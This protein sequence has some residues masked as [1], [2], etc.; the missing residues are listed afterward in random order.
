MRPHACPRRLSTPW[1]GIRRALALAMIAQ[2]LIYPLGA[3]GALNKSGQWGTPAELRFSG[4]HVAVMRKPG[5][6]SSTVFLFGESG[7]PQTMKFWRFL[8]QNDAPPAADTLL[9][10]DLPH[11]N[12]KRSDLFCSGHATLPD[13]KLLLV[14][15]AW[16]PDTVCQNVYS[17]DPA[18]TE[19]TESPWTQSATM[20]V[21]RW[22][23]TATPMAD[24]RVLASAGTMASRMSGFGGRVM[25]TGGL[26]STWRVLQTLEMAGRFAWAE[27]TAVPGNNPPDDPRVVNDYITHGEHPLGR[28]GHAFVGDPSGRGILIH[29]RYRQP[30]P[31]DSLLGDVWFMGGTIA[32]DDTTFTWRRLNPVGDASLP[33]TAMPVPRHRFAATWAGIE[34]DS[35][36]GMEQYADIEN[37]CYIHGGIDSNGK[38][39]GDLW[40]GERVPSGSVYYNWQWTRLLPDSPAT[41]RADH[42]MVYD[43]GPPDQHHAFAQLLL[44]GGRTSSDYETLAYA[45]NSTINTFGVGYSSSVI[46]LWRELT[47]DAENY[48]PPPAREGHT[49]IAKLQSRDPDEREFFLFGGESSPGTLVPADLWY[50]ERNEALADT[51]HYEWVKLT[52]ASGGPTPRRD[53]AMAYGI[54]S[55][56]LTVVGGD[57]NGSTS[58]DGYTN[59]VW[60]V[61]IGI[62]GQTMK[63][64]Q[65]PMRN[66]HPGPP[67]IAGMKMFAVGVGGAR[68]TRTLEAFS[69]SPG[70]PADS[71]CPAAAGRWQVVTDRDPESERKIADYPYMF[72]LPDGRMFNAGP[73]PGA[74]LSE[75]QYRR[76]YNM[77]IKRWTDSSGVD[78]QDAILFGSAVMYRPGKMLRAGAFSSEDDA[79]DASDRTEIAII[80]SGSNGPWVEQAPT[81]EK[82]RLEPRKNHNLTLL[83]TGDVLATGG[84]GEPDLTASVQRPRLWSVA[85]NRWNSD[86]PDDGERL[87][88]DPAKRNY[89]STAV[90]LPD[91]RVMTA[92]GEGHVGENPDQTSLSIYEPGYLFHSTGTPAIRPRVLKAPAV[93]T[94]G[95]TFT[96][97]LTDDARAA[98]ITSIALMRPGAVTHSFDQ[99]QRYV[100][101]TFSVAS[102]PTRLLVQA[103]ADA[104]VASPGDQMLFILDNR[105]TDAPNVPS[106]ARWTRTESQS[107]GVDS[108]DVVNPGTVVDLEG[109]PH[110]DQSSGELSWTEPADDGG[111]AASGAPV[112]YDIRY[113][114]ATSSPDVSDWATGW[115]TVTTSVPMVPGTPG[116]WV[117]AQVTGL[118]PNTKYWC[119][120]RT[121]DDNNQWSSHS[122]AALIWTKEGLECEGGSSGGGGGGG[123]SAGRAA[124]VHS[125]RGPATSGVF[126]NSLMDTG[127]RGI[128]NIDALRLPITPT[129]GP[130]RL[131]FRTH[132]GIGSQVDRARLLLVSHGPEEEVHVAGATVVVGAPSPIAAA[133]LLDGR[134][135]DSS[136]RLS[137]GGSLQALPGD[138]LD[139]DLGSTPGTVLVVEGRGTGGRGSGEAMGFVALTPDANGAWNELG[140]AAL[141][142][143]TDQVALSGLTGSRIRLA[144]QGGAELTGIH[145]LTLA[146]AAPQVTSVLPGGAH[147]RYS[148]D[149]TSFIQA[150]DSLSAWL[151]DLD[152]L[153]MEFTVPTG[154]EGTSRAVFLELNGAPVSPGLA[155]ATRGRRAPEEPLRIPVVYALHHPRPNPS[156]HSTTIGFSLP[157]SGVARLE[158]F[159]AQGRRVREY[160]ARYDAGDHWMDWDLCSNRGRRVASGVYTLRLSV[161]QRELK[162][163][164]VVLR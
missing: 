55:E 37:T 130:L 109:C 120:L 27:T 115:T 64:R 90:L 14:G 69:T 17:L 78:Q 127:P 108:A 135:L 38:I 13:G 15:G 41:R 82:Y 36:D 162:R 147:N 81:D 44:Y 99:N 118:S 89:H 71:L 87:A 146:S 67:P 151:V 98:H 4:T 20:A 31:V 29:G 72:Q 164:V 7:K 33:D 6:D 117:T 56:L 106:V 142:E 114:V 163:R 47:P 153:H 18:W 123:Y 68:V 102:N 132:T 159:D 9:M 155:Q 23:A 65:P 158:I 32:G 138:T 160:V 103:P 83:P 144:F 104:Y 46:G 136:L 19:E 35:L 113:K 28:D 43:P 126:E 66:F 93:L 150:Q 30:G 121:L 76:F 16:T 122:N 57:T 101:L 156:F 134:E 39:L 42:A 75:N 94:Y 34:R 107:L 74:N 133:R 112:S 124:G 61:F 21:E 157:E 40:R 73:A 1:T 49:M 8:P 80:T 152:T 3:S 54:D 145:S 62:Y 141:R 91:A 85:S 140:R 2:Q 48:D 161:A 129:P 70:S 148:G 131:W 84:H 50:L 137:D 92:G 139:L 116:A 58:A 63:W 97:T 10:F 96:L 86:E 45:D 53:V 105:G 59:E 125:L 25:G 12:D 128:P 51:N 154:Q 60:A 95:R 24:G 143:R 119:R 100:P 22:Y 149:I 77:S 5:T 88:L 11:P 79:S 52:S 26:D 111:L 110:G